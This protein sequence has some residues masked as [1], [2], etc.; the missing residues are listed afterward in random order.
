MEIALQELIKLVETSAP[1]LWRIALKQVSVESLQIAMVWTIAL[2]IFAVSLK[3]SMHF[4]AL[5]NN[6]DVS[7]KK[8]DYMDKF[9]LLFVF[10]VVS[11]LVWIVATGSLAGR[12]VNPEFYAIRVLMNYIQ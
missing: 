7:G 5:S 6:T 1:E 9:V 2:V 8:N 11:F 12:L 10:T 4:Y 3:Y